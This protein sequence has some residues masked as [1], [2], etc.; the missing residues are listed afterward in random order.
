MPSPL[1]P[2]GC[3]DGAR[4]LYAVRVYFE[5]TDLSGV[6]YHANYLR[7]F[8][9]ARSDMLRLI[10]IDQRAAHEAGEGAF[11]VTDLALRYLRPARLDDDVVIASTVAEVSRVT[12]SL[13]QQALRGDELLAE[14]RVRVAFVTPPG[15]ARRLPV[16]FHSA[17]TA[18][19]APPP[20]GSVRP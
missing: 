14:G 11:A 16:P 18:L 19:L 20:E 5:D 17:F 13:V 9:R 8:E 2:S 4:H 3:F 1:P 7:W 12:C 15:R 10:G 6:V